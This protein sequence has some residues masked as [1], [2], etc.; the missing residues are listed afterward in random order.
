[1]TGRL[2]P[3]VVA[4]LL[5]VTSCALAGGGD[6]VD[7]EES[8]AALEQQRRDVIAAART[9]LSAAERS[10]DGTTAADVSGTW[11]GCE[12]AGLEEYK[13]FHY[14]LQAR[15]DVSPDAE[16]EAPYL[17]P[18]RPTL[19]EAGFDVH[20]IEAGPADRQSM[21]ATKDDVTLSFSWTG[22]GPFVILTA[23]GPCIDVPEDERDDWLAR[24]DP[25]PEVR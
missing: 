11:R 4:A 6:D 8:R 13:N 3:L 1:M 2:T 24:H 15:V 10:L 9:S 17:E 7:P 23:S 25:P 21:T 14:R 12:S 20:D 19:E 16:V 18:L 22:L 5:L